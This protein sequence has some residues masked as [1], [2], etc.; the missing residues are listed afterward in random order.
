MPHA[1]YLVLALGVVRARPQ[2]N[3]GSIRQH[4]FTPI[5]ALFHHWGNDHV[6]TIKIL[7][8]NIVISRVFIMQEKRTLQRQPGSHSLS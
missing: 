3:P 6:G 4:N 5:F 8:L 7:V 1:R 2:M